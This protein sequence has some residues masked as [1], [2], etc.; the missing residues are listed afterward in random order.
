MLTIQRPAGL[1]VLILECKYYKANGEGAARNGYLQATAYAAE[2]HSRIGNLVTAV[3]VLPGRQCRGQ[4]WTVLDSGK[5]GIVGD[6]SVR[7]LSK[8]FALPLK[9]TS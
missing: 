4:G 8:A 6:D 7:A 9:G 2:V 3:A 5:V 1:D